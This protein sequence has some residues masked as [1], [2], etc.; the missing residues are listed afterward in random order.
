MTIIATTIFDQLGNAY[1][2]TSD[3]GCFWA[4]FGF[5][6]TIFGFGMILRMARRV[7]ST[8]NN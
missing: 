1:D 8:D 3:G 2:S 6:L 4:G 7:V 5:G